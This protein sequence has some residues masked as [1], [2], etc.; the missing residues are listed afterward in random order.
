MKRRTD[1][2]I[3]RPLYEYDAAIRAQYGCFAGV[4]EAGRG[5]LC[6]PVCVAA[7]IL[8][9]ENPVYGINDSKKLSEKKR[10]ALSV[11]I[12]DLAQRVG[13][14]RVE[15]EVIDRVNI[16]NATKLAFKAAYEQVG[17]AYVLIDALKGLDIPAHQQSIIHGDAL[18]YLIG[19]ASIV[20]KVTRDAYMVQMHEQYPEYG[21]VRNK[22]YG[23]KEHLE[24]LKKYGPCPLHRRSFLKNILEGISYG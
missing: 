21:F 15:P 6:G 2:E 22:G 9:P 8:D 7:C 1:E 23:T 16:L 10:F 17:C 19:A 5:P 14:G 18:S 12:L 3:S 13:I 11:Q 20:A 4:D 24:A